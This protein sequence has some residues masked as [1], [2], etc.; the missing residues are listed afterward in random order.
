MNLRIIIFATLLLALIGYPAYIYLDNRL[1]GGV[2]DLGNGLVLVD[3]KSMSTFPFDQNAG[4][5]DDV[6]Q[7]WRELNG[8]KIVLEGEMWSKNAAGPELTEFQL[9]YSIAQCCFSGPPQ[10]QH[11]V[12][13]VMRD[14]GAVPYLSGLVRVVGTLQ[15]NVQYDK[16]TGKVLTVY[17]MVVDDLQPKS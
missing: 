1:S 12:D 9:C 3:L 13:C 8:K 2:K 17:Q 7:K 10:V 14:G 4:R 6:P 16:E 15:V 5:I 11:F